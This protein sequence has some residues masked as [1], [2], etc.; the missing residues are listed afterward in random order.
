MDFSIPSSVFSEET[1]TI[2][3]RYFSGTVTLSSKEVTFLSKNMDPN[4]E[5]DGEHGANKR[6]EKDEDEENKSKEQDEGGDRKNAGEYGHG[7]NQKV[8]IDLVEPVEKET[9][10][11]NNDS[12]NSSYKGDQDFSQKNWFF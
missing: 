2:I 3:L 9:I 11:Y 7:D 1:L 4:N 12:L 6:K 5:E 10:V 8:V